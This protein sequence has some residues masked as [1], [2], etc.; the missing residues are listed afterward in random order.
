ML[1]GQENKIYNNNT[2]TNFES[3]QWEKDSI[4]IDQLF[5]RYSGKKPGASFMVIKDT[6]IIVNK[7]YGYANLDEKIKATANTNYRTASVTKQFTAMA[8]MMLIHQNKLSYESKLTE[9]FPDFPDY[10]NKI[11]I[12]HLLVHRSGLIDYM[13]LI[14][15]N[16]TEQILDDEVF[17]L[18]KEQSRTLFDPG[19][20]YEYSNSA[21]A[22]LAEVIAKLSGISFRHYMKTKIFNPLNMSNT[23]VYKKDIPI[24][25][26][27][28]GYTISGDK[29]TLTDQSTTSA[30][31]GDGGI[32]TSIT[33]YQKWNKALYSDQ[34]IPLEEFEKGLVSYY[35]DPKLL[36]QRY[37]NGW[38]IDYSGSIKI[39]HHSGHTKG[40]TNYTIR[41]PELKLCVVSFSNRNNDDAIIRIGNTIAALY[42][43]NRLPVP[44]D[45]FIESFFDKDGYKKA[46]TLYQ[47]LKNKK[48]H[49]YLF[50]EN[51]LFIIGKELQKQNKYKEAIEVYEFNFNEYPASFSTCYEL[52]NCYFSNNETE[53]A[54]IY[55]K[56]A[57]LLVPT[58]YQEIFK[59]SSKR[60]NK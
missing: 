9:I 34:L 12:K 13:N 31:Q 10:G 14:A 38:R 44:V 58:I 27:A 20:R 56:K 21:Y 19:S 5:R 40:F 33:D 35:D 26:R 43:D 39:T 11:T 48:D 30:V 41:I 49:N 52:A 42:S 18:M 46:I 32:Y 37:G 25:N 45:A 29:I 24:S 17:Q 22:V 16:R 59:T 50:S 23:S 54:R 4:I 51:A 6:N 2:S 55:Y 1:Y 28:Y 47:K 15:K 7:S 8:I 57:I 60:L 36:V 3:F 53:K